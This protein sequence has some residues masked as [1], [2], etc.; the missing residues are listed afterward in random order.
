LVNKAQGASGNAELKTTLQNIIFALKLP[1]HVIPVAKKMAALDAIIRSQTA[2]TCRAQYE[3]LNTLDAAVVISAYN[4]VVVDYSRTNDRPSTSAADHRALTTLVELANREG[5]SNYDKTYSSTLKKAVQNIVLELGRPG[6]DIPVDKKM[7][8]LTAIIE[9]QQS[10][11]PRRLAECL[12]QYKLLKTATPEMEQMLLEYVRD[13]KEECLIQAFQGSQFHVLNWVRTRVGQEYG[14]EVNILVTS[15]PHLGV[16]GRPSDGE[17]RRQFNNRYT[18]EALVEGVMTRIHLEGSNTPCRDYIQ[19]ELYQQA[20]R[21]GE[22][23]ED[24]AVFERMAAEAMEMFGGSQINQK[25]V[26]FLLR[27]IGIL[28]AA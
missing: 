25:G 16:G 27:G 20:R 23:P 28:N 22:D 10:C 26:I 8:A 1:N 12:R 2:D 21:R 24:E 3:R 9:A 7:R 14:L 5:V 18:P 11:A 15:D 17:I 4:A 13:L 19:L 6:S